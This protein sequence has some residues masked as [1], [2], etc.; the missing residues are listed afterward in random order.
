MVLWGPA[1]LWMALIF[2]GSSIPDVAGMPGGVS[3]KG[4]HAGVYAVLG[5]LFVRALSGASWRDVTLRI[6]LASIA[7]SVLYGLTDEWHQ[8]FVSG[9][10]PEVAD[11]V[12]DGAGASAAGF[13]V[14]A[15]S[16]IRHF[17]HPRG[18][19]DGVHQSSSRA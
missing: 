16:I 13:A 11:L 4:I 14:W 15:W 17:S 5:L 9:R 7:L 18:E 6:V 1:I 8:T 10:S 2:I 3:D 12:A 19:P